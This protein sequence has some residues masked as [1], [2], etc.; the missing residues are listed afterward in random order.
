MRVEFSTSSVL[1]SVT[2]PSGVWHEVCN[3]TYV[4][5]LEMLKSACKK[6][7]PV[8]LRFPIANRSYLHRQVKPYK[9][10]YARKAN[11]F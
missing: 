8:A 2:K 3:L 5:R 4:V 1:P 11:L 7:G 6:K 10:V 9:N